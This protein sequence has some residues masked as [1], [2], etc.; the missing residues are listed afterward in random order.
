MPEVIVDTS[1]LLYL[2][3]IGTL[4]WLQS[5]FN[6]I[7][8]PTAVILELQNGQTQG[9]DVPD[10]TVY[11][12]WQRVEPQTVPA[13]LLALELGAGET[14][15]LAF[16]LEKPGCV[17]LLDDGLARHAARSL[18][19]TVWGTLKLLLE[20]KSQGLTERISPLV[21][22]LR[23]SGMWISDEIRQR[24]LDLANE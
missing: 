24:I 7:Y 14:A 13:E 16:A 15:V 22:R 6:S 1:V 19:L 8:V 11:A 12:W 5:L 23:E 21:D 17:V 20:A 10:S 3:R 9:Y 2:Y 18:D 4:D